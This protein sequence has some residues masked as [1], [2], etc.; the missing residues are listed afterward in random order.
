MSETISLTAKAVS[1]LFPL[2][3]FPARQSHGGPRSGVLGTGGR[4]CVARGWLELVMAP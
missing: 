4:E 3:A 1:S 2:P